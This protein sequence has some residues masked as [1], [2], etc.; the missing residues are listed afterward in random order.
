V[1]VGRDQELRAL[2]DL[3]TL[4]RAGI[5]RAVAVTGDPGI[6]KTALLDRLRAE[7]GDA[8][9][10]SLVA[11]EVERVIP[12]AGL[13]TLLMPLRSAIGRLPEPHAGVLHDI[14]CRGAAS[15]VATMGLAILE[16]LSSLSEEHPVLLLVDDAQ[17]LD[18]ET[19]LVLGFARRRLD[20]HRVATVLAYRTGTVPISADLCTIELGG[21]D[22]GAAEELLGEAGVSPHVARGCSEACGGNP[23]AMLE[24]GRALSAEQRAGTRP[25]PEV[26]PVGERL[27]DWLSARLAALPART[28]EG[29][30][31]VAV[32]GTTGA[33]LLAE[34]LELVGLALGDLDPAEAQ[35]IVRRDGGTVRFAHPLFAS[36]A[37]ARATPA[38]RRAVHL[39]L[40]AVMPEGSADRAWHLAEGSDGTDDLAVDALTQVAARA[41]EQGAHLTAAD[42]WERISRL[43]RAPQARTHALAAAGEAAWSAGRP[44]LA[45]PWLRTARDL[46]PAGPERARATATLGQVIGWTESVRTALDLLR[47]EASAVEHEHPDLAVQLLAAAAGLGSLAVSPDAAELGSRA[48]EIGARCDPLTALAARTVATHARLAGGDSDID[49]DRLAE[50]DDVAQ[51]LEH[52]E[53][54]SLV[55]LAQMIGFDLMLRERWP[56]AR[57]TFAMVVRTA[58]AAALDAEVA[59]ASG[60]AAEIA[61]RTGRWIDARAEALVDAELHAPIRVL[62][63]TLGGAVLARVEAGLGVDETAGDQAGLA[64]ERGDRL[65]MHGLSAWGR[66]ALGFAALA[67]G[68]PEAALG[69]LQWV[70]HLS[71]GGR[72]SDPGTLWWQGDLLEALLATG[73]RD[74]ASRLVGELEA[75]ALATGR[76]WPAAVAARGRGVLEGDPAPAARSVALLDALGAPFEAARSR[77]ALAEL[78]GDEQREAV[79]QQAVHAFHRLGA[80]PWVERV[81]SLATTV[82]TPPEP[83]IAGLLSP[84]ELR[85]ARAVGRGATN[86]QV[87][88]ELALSPRTVDAHLRAIYRKVGVRSRTQLALRVSSGDPSL[89]EP[90]RPRRR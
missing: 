47:R 17:W 39:A 89:V 13:V 9:V 78:L 24:L 77:L 54:R 18:D 60:V 76:V 7:A 26:I 63:G 62:Q 67:A 53:G 35:G 73:E 3:L 1:L 87:A 68:D 2:Q 56:E 59:F 61:W 48:E 10:V 23:L 72:A 33:G 32:A 29:L 69:P 90:M 15:P 52:A 36:A 4:A 58:R 31:V 82:T 66:H 79:L 19:L 21:L 80:R 40:A 22:P 86:R 34:A 85:V 42:A 38:H 37:V 55:G 75:Q 43:V 14:T 49:P 81:R 71:E 5:P 70:W 50:V 12:L 6:G 45:A 88:D 57:T 51:L 16:L 20:G 30:A 41:G 11:A 27:D 65:G 84:A 64:V 8:T 25:L 28:E 44:D 46:A 83:A 74:D